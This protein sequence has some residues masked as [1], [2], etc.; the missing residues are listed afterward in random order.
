[1]F[2][3]NHRLLPLPVFSALFLLAST[4][5]AE[6]PTGP[7]APATSACSPACRTGFVCVES[8]CVSAC[9]PACGPNEVCTGAGECVDR[10][11]RSSAVATGASTSAPTPVAVAAS[12]PATV[13]APPGAE[14]PADAAS[15]GRIPSGFELGVRTGFSLPL[16]SVTGEP[17]DD[18]SAYTKGA[19]PLW[20]DV[21]YRLAHPNLF[22]GGYVNYGVVLIN[23]SSGS[24]SA[25]NVSTCGAAGTSCTANDVMVGLEALYHPSPESNF[26]PW[27]G[28]GI[29]VENLNGNITKGSAT[30]SE[31]HTG[32]DYLILQ[33]GGD[34]H[35]ST[36][37]A[38]GPLVMLGIGQ[39]GSFSFT[40]GSTT[41]SGSI[42]STALH[43]W[44]TLGLRGAFD[45]G[46][47]PAVGNDPV[48]APR[49]ANAGRQ[50]GGAQD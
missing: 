35:T 7:A 39:Y 16:G 14:G 44:L 13:S 23:D 4:V 49:S 6:P 38:F 43:E 30:A 33:A 20:F 22:I 9:N 10:S 21:G 11:P 5:H 19:V 28:A 8:Q 12:T 2:G 18:M 15:S 27:F 45:F 37:L 36:T 50:R 32:W 31:S 29:G 34:L 26:D 42:P 3:M 17:N 40:Q 41:A 1:L 48:T 25:S 24:T 47:S 46:S